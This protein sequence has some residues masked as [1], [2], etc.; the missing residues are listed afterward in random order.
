MAVTLLGELPGDIRIGHLGSIFITVHEGVLTH[1]VYSFYEQQ[2]ARLIA[3]HPRISIFA[4]VLGSTS[5][6]HP[7]VRERLNEVSKATRPNRIGTVV[8][9]TAGGLGAII[10]RTF[11]AALALVSPESIRATR[12]IASGVAALKALPGQL[13][14]VVADSTIA[15][16][17]EAFV[18]GRAPAR[19]AG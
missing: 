18:A 9:I 12:D 5:A 14:E 7:E 8:A 16:Q 1:E 6:P 11:L 10:T 19:Q 2:Q 13:P 15:A 17:I 4:V 3:L